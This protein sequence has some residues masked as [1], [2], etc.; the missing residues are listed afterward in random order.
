MKEIWKDIPGYKGYYQASS[1]GRIKRI[2][3]YQGTSV[4]KKL[5]FKIDA[6]Y[7]RVMLS[8]RNKKKTF[9]VHRLIAKTFLSNPKR[10]GQINHKNLNKLDNRA[11][12]L[13]WVTPKMNKHHWLR[14]MAH[15]R[16]LGG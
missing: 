6:G 14:S 13:E 11:T 15:G 2:R 3:Y 1:K 5:C 7:Y 10:Y 12:N 4:G 8:R 9:L 16:L